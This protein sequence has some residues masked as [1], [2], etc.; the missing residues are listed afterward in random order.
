MTRVD[1]ARFTICYEKGIIANWDNAEAN[2][3]AQ[4]RAQICTFNQWRTLI[5]HGG[6]A[7]P[8][9]SWTADPAGSATF[10]TVSGCTGDS[11]ST[12]FYTA[13]G[14]IGPCCLQYMKY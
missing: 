8:G 5:C 11:M 3:D 2:C 10:A 7:N 6:V 14:T 9:R 4:F 12:S 1:F 13:Q